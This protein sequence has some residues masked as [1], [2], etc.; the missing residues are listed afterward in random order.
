M[1]YGNPYSAYPY[2]GYGMPTYG[3][4]PYAQPQP[5]MVQPQAQGQQQPP[6]QQTVQQP[7][8]LQDFRYGTEEEAKGFIIYPNNYAWFIDQ[9]KGRIYYKYANS[10]GVSSIDY[11]KFEPINPDGTPL[12]PQE[13]T[14]PQVD[15]GQ[16]AKREELN[17]FVTIEQYN[18]LV[19]QLKSMQKQITGVKSNVATNSK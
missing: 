3:Q 19:E 18:L 9:P 6:I 17:G 15:F 16:F 11:F 14:T 4:R 13:P 5:T 10:A 8:T 12:K 2:S 7:I 1:N